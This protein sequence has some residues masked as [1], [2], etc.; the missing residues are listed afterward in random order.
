[1]SQQ[2]NSQK[3]STWIERALVYFLMPTTMFERNQNPQQDRL[4]PQ[5]V[6]EYEAQNLEALSKLLV[7]D[8]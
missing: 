5:I 8:V 6:S 2:E 4:L 1:M 7:I 3:P